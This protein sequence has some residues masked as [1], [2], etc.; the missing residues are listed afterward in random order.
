MNTTNNPVAILRELYEMTA[1]YAISDADYGIVCKAAAVINEADL[2][3]TQ[4]AGDA[5]ILHIPACDDDRDETNLACDKREAYEAAQAAEGGEPSDHEMQCRTYRKLHLWDFFGYGWGAAIA[6]YLAPPAPV[7]AVQTWRDAVLDQCAI[8]HAQFYED[9][10]RKTLENLI[11]WHVDV[12]HD[13]L[14]SDRAAPVQAAPNKKCPCDQ[15]WEA[16][17]DCEQPP[18]VQAAPDAVADGIYD[19]KATWCR[20]GWYDGRIEWHYSATLLID[21]NASKHP[22]L[23]NEKP[24]G[25]YP[26]LPH[27]PTAPERTSEAGELPPLPRAA[28]LVGTDLESLSLRYTKDQMRA[29][30][31]ACIN[32]F[33]EETK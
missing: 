9:D 3:A 4:P 32:K 1:R 20:E 15:D 17:I 12:S 23:A 7:Q 14:V 10:P 21:K 5:P 25:F 8:A 6:K 11:S 27:T 16:C 24:Y 2:A 18:A 19:N 26:D 13:P 22:L 33:K 29:Y 30:G 31:Q 28:M